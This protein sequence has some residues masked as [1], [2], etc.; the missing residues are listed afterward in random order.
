MSSGEIEEF[1]AGYLKGQSKS[2]EAV[3]CV[4]YEIVFLAIGARVM[5]LYM[6]IFQATNAI[7]RQNRNQRQSQ[8]QQQQQM[9]PLC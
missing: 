8:Q 1:V 6:L 7:Y 4:L 2:P 5:Q 9:Q 3:T